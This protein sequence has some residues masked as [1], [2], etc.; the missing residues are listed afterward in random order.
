MLYKILLTSMSALA[1]AVNAVPTGVQFSIG[2]ACSEMI[3]QGGPPFHEGWYTISQGHFEQVHPVSRD[4]PLRVEW[5][6]RI[7]GWH[8]EEIGP[9]EF[10]I[11]SY[12]MDPLPAATSDYYERVYASDDPR[13]HST[14][15]IES[16]GDNLWTIKVPGKNLVWKRETGSNMI[17]LKPADGS[18][19]EHW[20]FGSFP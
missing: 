9:D 6:T 11:I 15:S 4:D 12:D 7:W 13:L 8:V 20:R 19:A 10:K 1:L 3:T 5:G 2:A 18:A 16:A 17:A 14:W